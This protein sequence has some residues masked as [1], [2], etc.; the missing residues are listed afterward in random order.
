MG[1]AAKQLGQKAIDK[2]KDKARL[3]HPPPLST[4]SKASLNDDKCILP[5]ISSSLIVHAGPSL[6]KK[7]FFDIQYFENLS[8]AKKSLVHEYKENSDIIAYW[9]EKFTYRGSGYKANEYLARYVAKQ[10]S[11]S[12]YVCGP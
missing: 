3:S 4:S 10:V 8:K 7:C 11:S 12:I 2:A 6:I 1:L 5:V 9:Y